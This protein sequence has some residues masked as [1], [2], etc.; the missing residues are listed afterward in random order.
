MV[1]RFVAAGLVFEERGRD[2]RT[3]RVPVD[4]DHP[5]AALP[6]VVLVDRASASAS[7]IVAGS[8]QAHGRAPLVGQRTFGKGSVQVAYRLRDGSA[9]NLTVQHWFL[10]DGRSINGPGLA[11]DVPV[12]LQEGASMFDVVQ[13]AR[14]HA[15]DAQLNRAGDPG[16]LSRPRRDVGRCPPADPRTGTTRRRWPFCKAEG[17]RGPRL[18][19]RRDGM[20]TVH[21]QP[22]TR[23]ELRSRLVGPEPPV[24]VDALKAEVY[25]EG[26]LPGAI[27]LPKPRVDELASELLPDKDREVVVYCGRLA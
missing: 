19:R 20:S 25:A 3:D 10:P 24:V 21:V 23:D 2:G 27:N 13:P 1:S 14:G 16:R 11:P 17:A 15:S 6:L 12:D 4:G 7:E 22:I 8:L 18:G 5:A 9:L 26:H